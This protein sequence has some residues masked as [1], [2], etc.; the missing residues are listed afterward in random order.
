[1]PTVPGTAFLGLLRL[2]TYASRKA[3]KAVVATA[4]RFAPKLELSSACSCWG[5]FLSYL[6]EIIIAYWGAT[7][8]HCLGDWS[9]KSLKCFW[10]ELHSLRV[11]CVCMWVCVMDELTS[12]AKHN[13]FA[14]NSAHFIGN[15]LL[16]D[17]AVSYYCLLFTHVKRFCVLLLLLMFLIQCCLLL[18]KCE[19]QHCCCYCCCCCCSTINC[20]TGAMAL[21]GALEMEWIMHLDCCLLF[22]RALVALTSRVVSFCTEYIIIIVDFVDLGLWCLWMITLSAVHQGCMSPKNSHD[23]SA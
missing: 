6:A 8:R 3:F 23:F 17:M 11:G 20:I 15:Q 21:I 18:L 19:T 2:T 4:Y 5:R 22:T 7:L 1:M 14:L 12:R 9:S 10:F 16:L 13:N